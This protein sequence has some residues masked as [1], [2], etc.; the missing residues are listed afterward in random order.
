MAVIQGK[1]KSDEVICSSPNDFKLFLGS[2]RRSFGGDIVVAVESTISDAVKAVLIHYKAVV[3]V[4]PDNLC[5]QATRSIFCGS[6]EER[7]PASVFRYYFYEKWA[8]QYSENSLLMYVDFRDVFFQS[9]PFEY[10]KDEWF[11]EYQLVVFQEFHPNMVIN[12]C[13]FNTRIMLECYGDGSLRYYGNRV[14]ISSG[15]AIGSRDAIIIWSRDMT[16]Q[17]QEA[18]GRAVDTRCTSGGIDH[19]FINWLVYSNKLRALMRTKLVHQGEGI[20][21]T[22]GGL[23]PDTVSANITGSLREFWKILDKQG[24]ILNWN[25][26]VSPVVHQVDHFMEEL[27]YIATDMYKRLGVSSLPSSAIHKHSTQAY[28]EFTPSKT[29][30][31]DSPKDLAVPFDASIDP[32]DIVDIAW[33][34]IESTR[35]LWGCISSPKFP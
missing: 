34:T 25:G 19:S 31:I 1:G 3:Y 20:V 12:R 8:A 32:S 16:N 29:L 33:Q 35:C 21:N 27:E 30:M 17:L 14:I 10:R 2:A 22:V 18:P 6:E 26:E 9:N 7:V 4:L 5:S 28:A 23:R 13:M 15:A 11:P 24:R